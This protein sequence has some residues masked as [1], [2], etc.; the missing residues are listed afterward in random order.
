MCNCVTERM[1][2]FMFEGRRAFVICWMEI[3][4][5]ILALG[6]RFDQNT[7]EA[8]TLVG[9]NY[10]SQVS[11][12]LMLKTILIKVKQNLF[13]GISASVLLEIKCNVN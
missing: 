1:M 13:V 10:I 3:L 8:E 4:S 12:A 7:D 9:E 2:E 6:D 5:W 11:K